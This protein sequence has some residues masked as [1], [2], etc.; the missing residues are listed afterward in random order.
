[1]SSVSLKKLE[2]T[3][4]SRQLGAAI[5]ANGEIMF[6]KYTVCDDFHLAP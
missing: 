3:F 4:V 5:S 1:M 2:V 6:V